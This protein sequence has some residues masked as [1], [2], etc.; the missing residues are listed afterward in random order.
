MTPY[1]SHQALIVSRQSPC[2]CCSAQQVS[3][4]RFC[5]RCACA[6]SSRNLFGPCPPQSVLLFSSFVPFQAQFLKHA[7]TLAALSLVSPARVDPEDCAGRRPLPRPR[8]STSPKLSLRISSRTDRPNTTQGPS[9]SGMAGRKHRRPPLVCVAIEP[10]PMKS[11]LLAIQ[12]AMA[13]FSRSDLRP[14]FPCLPRR[15]N[16]PRAKAYFFA[17][18][19]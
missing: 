7:H 5:A 14:A 8:S 9:L 10:R 4:L 12:S 15:N 3:D 11:L 2:L 6:D 18:L 16:C 1:T 17:R 13:I 19:V